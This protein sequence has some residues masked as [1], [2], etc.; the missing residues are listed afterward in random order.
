VVTDSNRRVFVLDDDPAVRT[1]VC[2]SLVANG[3]EPA[4]FGSTVPFLTQL[5]INPPDLV[6]LDLVLGQSDAV[7]MINHLESLKYRGRVLLISGR[8]EGALAE[9][10]RI[11]RA[12]GLAMLP[13]LSKPFRASELRE[14]LNA[15]ADVRAE[16][17][18]RSSRTNGRRSILPRRWRR[19]GWSF[20]TSRRSISNH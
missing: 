18:P 9:I 15:V 8:G 11:G 20:G 2:R 3:F 5:R 1:T 13:P 6:V 16:A 7:E 17:P 14:R 10:H 4:E 19:R 12:H